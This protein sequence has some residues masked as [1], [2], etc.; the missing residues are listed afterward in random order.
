MQQFSDQ[1][2]FLITFLSLLYWHT[3]IFVHSIFEKMIRWVIM[4]GFVPFFVATSTETRMITMF[5]QNTPLLTLDWMKNVLLLLN[6]SDKAFHCSKIL[7]PSGFRLNSL[8]LLFHDI[9]SL[10]CLLLLTFPSFTSH[11]YIYIKI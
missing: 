4:Y 10:P 5:N 7:D 9:K 6:V 2:P 3:D 11:N 1:R 8:C